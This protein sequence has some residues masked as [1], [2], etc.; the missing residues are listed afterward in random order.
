MVAKIKVV[1]NGAYGKWADGGRNFHR[2]AIGIVVPSGN[3]GHWLRCREAAESAVGVVIE[4]LSGMLATVK[5]RRS[6]LHQSAV[7]KDNI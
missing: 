1:A 5:P 6:R 4:D 7:V 3:K 2:P